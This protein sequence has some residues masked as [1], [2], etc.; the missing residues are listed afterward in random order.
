MCHKCEISVSNS[1]KAI[2]ASRLE[3]KS[4]VYFVTSLYFGYYQRVVKLS[5]ASG[6]RA[7]RESTSTLQFGIQEYS[8]LHRAPAH[9]KRT[10]HV[11][12]DYKLSFP[13]GLFSS[14]K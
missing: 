5:H 3:H 9:H 11:F 7:H 1:W 4:L 14:N 8:V 13:H 6:P 12:L 10:V 2:V